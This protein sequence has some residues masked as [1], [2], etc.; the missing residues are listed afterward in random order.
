M[1]IGKGKHYLTDKKNDMNTDKLQKV[2]ISET[3]GE[4]KDEDNYLNG[5][6][7]YDDDYV[8]WLEQKLVTLG[9]P[10]VTLC[11]FVRLHCL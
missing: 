10:S 8:E 5:R 9:L 4:I 2:Y 1:L 6:G 7:S 3:G 11:Y